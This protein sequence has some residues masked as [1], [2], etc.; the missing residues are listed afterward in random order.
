MTSTN[1]SMTKTCPKCAETIQ[2]AAVVCRY[3]GYDYEKRTIP[4]TDP[5][6]RTN[7]LAVASLVL[8]VVWVYGF[9]SILAVIFGHVALSQ[10]KKTDGAQP[11]KGLA[12]AGLVLG[13]VGIVGAVALVALLIALGENWDVETGIR[14]LGVGGF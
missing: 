5:A 1:D 2:A 13:Y 8:G 11:G 6:L 4:A 9:T 14:S 12:I 7:G 10:I 3:C